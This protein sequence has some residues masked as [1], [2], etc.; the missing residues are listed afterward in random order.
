MRAKKAGH[1]SRNG[2]SEVTMKTQATIQTH[3]LEKFARFLEIHPGFHPELAEET[4]MV[5][6]FHV[7]GCFLTI[8]D[9]DMI[10]SSQ[11]RQSPRVSALLLTTWPKVNIKPV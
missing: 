9:M 6:G 2:E 10:I 11:P 5:C 8:A 1:R 4:A 7:G 3:Q